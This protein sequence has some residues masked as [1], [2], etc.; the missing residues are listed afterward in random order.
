MGLV[1]RL[2]TTEPRVTA[3]SLGNKPVPTDPRGSIIF[4]ATDVELNSA[5]PAN[6]VINTANVPVSATVEVRIVPL[7][8]GQSETRIAASFQSGNLGS[9][10]WSATLPITN[11]VSSFTVSVIMP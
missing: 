3:V 5:T 8:Q 6:L 11:G 4:G 1:G 9:A 7:T 2:Q 10:T